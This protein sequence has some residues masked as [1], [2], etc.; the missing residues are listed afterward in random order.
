MKYLSLPIVKIIWLMLY[1]YTGF[2]QGIFLANHAQVIHLSGTI[3]TPRISGLGTW[4]A[5]PDTKTIFQSPFD[6]EL[7]LQGGTS[8]RF[9]NIIK[10]NIGNL[11]S[12][13]PVRCHAT[14][15]TNSG[16]IRLGGNWSIC[17]S[18]S[19]SLTGYGQGCF[20]E[21]LD[22]SFLKR[23]FCESYD[24]LIFPI[25]I[26]GVF[27]PINC[28]PK[29]YKDTSVVGASISL[30]TDTVIQFIDSPV[31]CGL[32][33]QQLTFT[34][35]GIFRWNIQSSDSV[36]YSVG[37][38]VQTTQATPLVVADLSENSAAW[39]I[40]QEQLS[41]A[42]CN[43][44]YPQ[45][46]IVYASGY[47][48]SNELFLATTLSGTLPITGLELTARPV[49]NA[50]IR[51]S[52]STTTEINNQGF[53]VERSIDGISFVVQNFI[54]SYE[55]VEKT[56]NYFFDDRN[57]D[58]NILY[59]YRLRQVDNDDNFSYSHIVSAKISDTDIC[60]FTLITITG[61]VIA[62]GRYMSKHDFFRN[63]KYLLESIPKQVLLLSY[64]TS[65]G[66]SFQEKIVI[67]DL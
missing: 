64:R 3:V 36:M 5:C 4:S 58:Y 29:T 21:I 27:S 63:Q 49:E 57:V 53:F 65:S 46:S 13:V 50:S 37:I 43:G 52:W 45:D 19:N 14:S 41:R 18:D 28:F 12:S 30:L 25:G 56:R 44:I 55:A 7:S 39:T 15:F 22:S 8:S 34:P 26:S 42:I 31:S 66:A 47:K 35:H 2:S 1:S 38:P 51:V 67:N 20:F 10:A 33:L 6:T 17:S 11:V 32:L 40:H 54:P 59:Y 60:D 24:S 23:Y 48:G 16:T 9:G 61:Q 62:Y